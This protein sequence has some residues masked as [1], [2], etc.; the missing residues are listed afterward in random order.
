M[1]TKLTFIILLGL[2]SIISNAQKQSIAV[3]NFD[4][5]NINYTPEQLGNIA[6]ME[7]E[8]VD[9]FEVI[10]R[11]DVSYLAKKENLQYEECYGKLC[12]VEI[13]KLLKTDKILTGSVELY[14]K[15]TIVTLRLI[16]VKTEKTK[17]LEYLDLKDEINAMLSISIMKL[18]DLPYNELL[19]ERITRVDQYENAI[20]AEDNTRLNLNGPRLGAVLFTGEQAGL[21]ALPKSQGGIDAIPVMFM[22]GYQFE[23]QYINQG[24]FQA[25]FEIVPAITGLDQS[26]IIPSISILNGLRHNVNG[27]EFA[28][29]PVLSLTS[30]AKGYYD[31][32][33]I[34]YLSDDLEHPLTQN[35]QE[36]ER[37]DSRGVLQIETG[38]V[39]AVGKSLKSGRLNIPIN[40]YIIPSRH[41]LK[42]GLTFGY[43]AK[44]KR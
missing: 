30:K 10:D 26:Y 32:N 17:V 42:V 28:L 41:S 24:N 31:E 33:G 12:L 35:Y 13:G 44:K 4:S 36:I 23:F 20:I 40:A 18:F 37:F 15:T 25:L 7:L 34:W 1:K 22:F 39:F 6:R 29:G 2:I 9:T 14:G 21:M 38:F 3:L 5:Q 11:Y 27:W 19:N 8:K 43:N 16:D